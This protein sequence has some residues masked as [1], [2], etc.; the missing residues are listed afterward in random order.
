MW[1]LYLAIGVVLVAALHAFL[2][3]L[4]R[5]PEQKVKLQKAVAVGGVLAGIVL[6]LRV[7]ASSIASI[8]SALVV[9][10]PFLERYLRARGHYQPRPPAD[11]S[12]S[13]EE[14]RKV[15]GVAE[16]ASREDIQAAY[17]RLMQRIHPDQ[18]GSDYLASK[19]NQA[20]DIL[21]KNM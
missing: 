14:A 13:I 12:M 20:R 6:L 15:L 19:L 16:N 2:T 7:G 8:L 1:V 10:A 3:W 21:L 11:T 18:G 9:L 5:H 17:V 4:S